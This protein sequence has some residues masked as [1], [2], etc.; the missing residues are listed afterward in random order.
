MNKTTFVLSLLLGSLALSPIH[1]SR[2]SSSER[3][4]PLCSGYCADTCDG[5]RFARIQ[6]RLHKWED[7]S[8]GLIFDCFSGKPLILMDDEAWDAKLL[9]HPNPDDARFEMRTRGYVQDADS[10]YAIKPSYVPTDVPI[11]SDFMGKL[12]QNLPP[13]NTY[14]LSQG[15]NV[16]DLMSWAA[17]GYQRNFSS[18]VPDKVFPNL[19]VGEE[20]ATRVEEARRLGRMTN[21]YRDL[22]GTSL[23]QFTPRDGAALMGD[24]GSRFGASVKTVDDKRILH[25]RFQMLWEVGRGSDLLPNVTTLEWTPRDG[26]EPRMSLHLVGKG[27]CFDTGGHN[28][29]HEPS[30]QATMYGDKGGALAQI[31]LARMIMEAN[32]PIALTVS[33]GWVVNTPGP[34]AQ[35]QSDIYELFVGTAENGNTDAEGR[36]VMG[37]ILNSAR[38]SKPFDVTITMAT[39]TGAALVA[40]GQNTGIIHAKGSDPVTPFLVDGTKRVH[41]PVRHLG[42]DPRN[43]ELLK[44]GTTRAD[45]RTTGGSYGGSSTADAFLRWIATAPIK[46]EP[47][48][49]PVTQFVHYDIAC[50]GA[51]STGLTPG[52]KDMDMFAVRGAFEGLKNYLE[53]FPALASSSS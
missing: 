24:L 40:V 6:K 34:Q 47:K 21:M 28:I 48:D 19:V 13:H 50:A 2:A 26:V 46:T 45:V 5:E 9:N 42:I 29:K 7:S 17:G 30:S 1:E 23:N 41:D 52:V 36:L 32:L 15:L 20:N 38:E 18:S 11:P 39:L 53:K 22:I 3:S 43:L 37:A 27:V 4:T 51:G 49:T 8:M 12:R 44:A 35:M 10:F 16:L 25:D 33:N 14:V 31:M